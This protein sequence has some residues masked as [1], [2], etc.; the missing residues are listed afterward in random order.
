MPAIASRKP[1]AIAALAIFAGLS[2]GV[3]VQASSTCPDERA[4]RQ[5]PT[6]LARC[7]ELERNVRHPDGS[8]KA[9]VARVGRESPA[10]AESGAV[11][12]GT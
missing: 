10:G 5:V 9:V 2:T 1:S 11:P 3:A 8:R 6:N 7:T 12:S 4:S